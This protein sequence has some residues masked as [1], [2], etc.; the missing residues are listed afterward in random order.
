MNLRLVEFYEMTP[1]EFFLFREG[2][3][4]ARDTDAKFNMSMVRK[5]MFASIMPHSKRGL[6]ETDIME[7]EWEEELVVEL[8]EEELKEQ[9]E[10]VQR[11][12]DVWKQYDARKGTC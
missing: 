12:I 5:I 6:K 9:H 2:F 8:T 11:S 4:N 10:E 3:I 7:F 1:R